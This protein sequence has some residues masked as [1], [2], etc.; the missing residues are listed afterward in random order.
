MPAWGR[1][2]NYQ[3]FK[4]LCDSPAQGRI[5]LLDRQFNSLLISLSFARKLDVDSVYI[6]AEEIIRQRELLA[7]ERRRQDERDRVTASRRYQREA[8]NNEL[9]ERVF[10]AILTAMEQ[11]EE[12]R[13]RVLDISNHAINLLDNLYARATSMRKLEEYAAFL[14]WLEDGLLRAV[15]LPPFADLS[16]PKRV[17]VSTMRNAMGFIGS[18]DLRILVPNYAMQNWIPKSMEP[19]N[20]LRQKVWE[21]SLGTAITA[22]VLAELDGELN[23]SLAFVIGMFHDTGKAALARLYSLLF[24]DTQRELLSELR[25]EVRSERYN[26]LLELEPSELFLRNLMLHFAHRFTAKLFGSIQFQFIPFR[27][28]YDDFANAKSVGELSGFARNLYQAQRYTQFR[29]MYSANFATTD[30]GKV[31]CKDAELTQSSLE[32]L[33]AVSLKRLRLS[34]GPV[35]EA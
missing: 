10:D 31:L 9:H 5:A 28:V 7:V 24:D 1:I 29:M 13:A 6:E 18:E 35:G 33:R 8:I 11:P 4:A 22:Q 23:P 21:H 17:K 27:A 16:D 30:D 14:P 15:N 32:V 19:F 12:L 20:L 25:K 3:R 2:L 26:A 34:R